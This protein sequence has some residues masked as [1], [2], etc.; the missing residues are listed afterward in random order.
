MKS[1]WKAGKYNHCGTKHSKHLKKLWKSGIYD[2]R[3]TSY[4]Q[5]SEYSKKVSDT[6]K[7]RWEEGRYNK[8]R[9]AK[10]SRSNTGRPAWNRGRKRAFHKVCKVCS[11]DFSTT[12]PSQ[13][14]C[15]N[16]ECQK[17]QHKLRRINPQTEMLRRKKISLALRNRVP[18]NLTRPS[19]NSIGFRQL[20]M[21]N[22][23]KEYFPNAMFEYRVKTSK[24]YRILDTAIPDCMLDF[25]YNGKVHLMRSVMEHDRVRK[26]EL[27]ALG[28]SIIVIDKDNF[29]D[30]HAICTSLVRGGE[31]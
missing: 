24:T 7:L 12:K 27:E 28:W 1:R 20:Q 30:L 2:N 17:L 16:P 29:Y 14:A 11:G 15:F 21:Y 18:Q 4:K 19:S 6:V 31:E 8:E 5:D 25:E 10:I 3:D 23:I 26:E 22:V 13:T 9:N